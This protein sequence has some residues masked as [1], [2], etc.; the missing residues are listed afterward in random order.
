MALKPTVDISIQDFREQPGLSLAHLAQPQS[1]R[2]FAHKS[3][4]RYNGSE[5]PTRL[6]CLEQECSSLHSQSLLGEANLGDIYLFRI[7]HN[8][9]DIFLIQQRF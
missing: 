1:E 9:F 4:L 6:E 5:G 7:Y 2:A 8:K 3:T